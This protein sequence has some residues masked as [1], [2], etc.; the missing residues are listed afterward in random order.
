[1][2]PMNA[3]NRENA[4]QIQIK[5]Q[6]NKYIMKNQYMYLMNACDRKTAI[7]R[8]EY[9]KAAIK[10]IYYEKSNKCIE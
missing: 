10:E 1:M 3:C 6:L 7:N 8:Q 5:Q 9:C 2:Y 4:L